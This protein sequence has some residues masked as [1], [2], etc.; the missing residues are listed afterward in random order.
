MFKEID[1]FF[2]FISI[3]LGMVLIYSCVEII[4]DRTPIKSEENICWK[5]S[6]DY[7]F[8]KLEQFSSY[9]I[10]SGTEVCVKTTYKQ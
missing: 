8:R 3:V 10:P 6:S 5:I 2:Q 4:W 7:K 9:Y 1:P